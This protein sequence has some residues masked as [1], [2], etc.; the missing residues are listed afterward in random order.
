MVEGTREQGVGVGDSDAA[1]ITPFFEGL[2]HEDVEVVVAEG[3]D[4]V[5][6]VLP[7]P[8]GAVGLALADVVLRIGRL[9]AQ[10]IDRHVAAA[11]AVVVQPAEAG[12]E[13][14]TLD[15]SEL[16]EEVGLQAITLVVAVVARVVEL[17]ER[18]GHFGAEVPVVSDDVLVLIPAAIVV[19]GRE[20][21]GHR[22]ERTDVV[23]VDAADLDA[24]LVRGREG[25]VLTELEDVAVVL[26]DQGIVGI[27][28]EG[29]AVVLRGGRIT[30]RT[31]LVEFAETDREAGN[32]AAAQDVEGGVADRSVVDRGLLEPVGAVPGTGLDAGVLL[33]DQVGPVVRGLVGGLV[34]QV[35]DLHVLLGVQRSDTVGVRVLPAVVAVEGNLDLAGLTLLGCHE[36][37]AV[38]GTGTVD[39]A[40]SR[41]LQDVDGLDIVGGESGDGAVR[42]AVHNVERGVGTGS[43]HTADGHLVAFA[44][45]TGILGDVH[46]GGLALQGAE[47]VD[48]VRVGEL[49]SR[50]ADRRTGH[51]FFTL[52]TITDHDGLLKHFGVVLEDDGHVF[53]G[54]D[55]AGRVADAGDFERSPGGDAETEDAVQVSR[56][57]VGRAWYQDACADDRLAVGINH[58]AA[59]GTIL[60][61]SLKTPP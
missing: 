55:S 26:A 35:V 13:G 14:E 51:E 27:Q 25:H 20:E 10:L 8:A 4:P 50:D 36:D 32:V 44:R 15:G 23:V 40:G 29:V 17:S 53:G 39:G 43:T 18:V 61:G 58:F 31:G 16:Q 42:H 1:A 45:L 38:G 22:E 60:G 28:T 9:G 5:D 49:V 48:G 19:A 56:S 37:D 7:G 52:D 2:T 12:A 57:T 54:G 33:G 11:L 3:L 47:R 24:L 59:D 30:E 41:I 21:R 46:A 34:G 6:G